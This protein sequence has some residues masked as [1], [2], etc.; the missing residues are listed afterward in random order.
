MNNELTDITMILDKSGS[1]HSIR[2]DTIG[3]VNTFINKQKETPGKATLSMVQF[4]SRRE[5]LYSC[6]DIKDVDNLTINTFIPHGNTALLDTIGTTIKETGVRLSAMKE[7]DR[8]GKVLFVIITDGEENYSKEFTKEQIAEMIKLQETT[9]N[10]DFIY[11]GANQDAITVASTMGMSAGNSFSFAA[12]AKGTK[13]MFSA[14]S[15]NTV[16]YRGGGLVKGHYFSDEDRAKQN[17]NTP[18]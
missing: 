10:W 18:L 3:G 9:Y 15:D 8:P 16:K 14:V 6:K 2:N 11:L 5:V 4:A 1:M 13:D 7:E 12:N 17:L